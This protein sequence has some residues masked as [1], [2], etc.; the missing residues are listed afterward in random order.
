MVAAFSNFNIRHPLKLIPTKS[1]IE[2]LQLAFFDHA[3]IWGSIIHVLDVILYQIILTP[4][5]FEGAMEK[6]CM[7]SSR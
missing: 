3:I 6:G 7:N 5:C 2:K 1:S 4:L